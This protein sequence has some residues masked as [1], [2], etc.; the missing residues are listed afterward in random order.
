MTESRKLKVSNRLKVLQVLPSLNGGGVERGTLEI[1]EALVAAGH[2]SWVL[3]AGG[4]L[5]GSLEQAGGHHKRWNIGK[6]SPFTLLQVGALRDWLNQ[7]QF[8]IIHVRSRMPA[9]V[10]WLAWRKMPEQQRPHLVSTVHGMHSVSRYSAIV[11]CGERVVAV[12]EAVRNYILNNYPETPADKIELIYRGI[13]E[14]EFP[15]GYQPPEAWRTVWQQQFP[16]LV[17]QQVITLPGRLTRLKGHLTFLEVMAALKKEGIPVKGLIVGGED[18]KRKSYAREVYQRCDALGLTQDVLFTGH[19]NDM[20][21]IYAA[22]DIVLTLSSKPESFG[23]TAAEALSMGV[24][25]IGW[26]HGGIAEILREL[27]PEGAVTKD[28]S[29]SLLSAI[30]HTLENKPSIPPNR[31]FLLSEMKAQTLKLYDHLCHPETQ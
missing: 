9:W 19:R 4:R 26:N 15:H 2:E 21:E 16:Q 17:G 3:S 30:R 25:V 7:N 5:V 1:S 28:D 20:K 22:S 8:D 27:Y 29:A 18:D 6:K 14:L 12:S 11:T 31:R 13:D 23:R 24:P 10:V